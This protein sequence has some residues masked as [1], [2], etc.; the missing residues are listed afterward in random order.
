LTFRL[1]GRRGG[2]GGVNV[3]VEICLL[4]G[5]LREL[6]ARGSGGGGS[7]GGGS[8]FFHG[9]G[10]RSDIRGEARRAQTGREV[11]G[12]ERRDVGRAVDVRDIVTRRY[13]AVTSA[14][15]AV[16]IFR[17]AAVIFRG[18]VEVTRAAVVMF[19]AVMVAVAGTNLVTQESQKAKK[20][21]P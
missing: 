12:G 5:A 20:I 6:G 4:D 13:I 10:R 9:N 16:I 14:A 11:G 21:F 19:S 15:I 18:A 7:G 8:S 3:L 17:G 2:S 1:A